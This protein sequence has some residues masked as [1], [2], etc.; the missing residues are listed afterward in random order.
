MKI[1]CIDIGTGTQDILLFDSTTQIE[2]CLQLVMP[3]PTV[4]VANQIRA[5]TQRRAAVLLTGT[6]MGGGPSSW[7]AEDHVRAGLPIFATRDAALSFNDE[8]SQVEA[9]GIRVVSDDEAARLDATRVELRDVDM[10]ALARAFNAFGVPF[11]FDALAVAVF[12]HGNAPPGMS[13]RTFR[14]EFLAERIRATGKLSG[15]AFMRDAIPERLTRM[16]AVANSIQANSIQANHAAG[17]HAADNHE[18]GN[19]AAGNHA[20]DNHEAGNHE[21]GNHEAG[22]HEAGNHEAGNHEAGN[23]EAGNHEAGN[24][25]AGNH[26]A[27]NHEAGNHEGLPLL[28]MDTAPAAVRGALDDDLVRRHPN[29]VIANLGNFHTLAFRFTDGAITG[30]FEHH[31]GELKQP[32]LEN[33]LRELANGTLTNDAIFY[34]QGHGAVIFDPR[35][36]PLDPPPHSGQSFLAVTGPRRALLLRSE[37][38]PYFAVPYGDMMLAGDFGLLHAYADLNPNVADE[39]ESALAKSRVA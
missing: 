32:Q 31:T 9:T 10:S 39:I 21:A 27:G 18:A 29:A 4:L 37:L 17:N 22:N 38:N 20:A 34:S 30:V 13:D 26:E 19:H 6:I 35:A 36:Q 23:H 12:D 14:F 3:S 15:F 7:A 2:N 24:H 1:L 28:V 16:Q 8:L 33:F 5:A 11:E 25:E